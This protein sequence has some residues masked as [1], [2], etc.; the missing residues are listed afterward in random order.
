MSNQNVKQQVQN[1]W[2]NNTGGL[3]KAAIARKFGISE[4][5]VGRY[6]SEITSQVQTATTKKTPAKPAKVVTSA[7]TKNHIR[8][9]R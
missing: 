7:K 2:I 5:S 8:K 1:A 4:R 3:T 9:K 6:I